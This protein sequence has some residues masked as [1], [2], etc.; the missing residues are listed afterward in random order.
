MKQIKSAG[1]FSS[2]VANEINEIRATAAA[3]APEI[4]TLRELE[5]GWVA[6]GG[7]DTPVWVPH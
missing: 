2:E 1:V 3:A 4:R 7:D 6:G 5:M